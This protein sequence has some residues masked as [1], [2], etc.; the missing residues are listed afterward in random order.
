MPREVVMEKVKRYA[1]EIVPSFTA[2]AYF[3]VGTANCA[4]RLADALSGPDRLP[5][6][7]GAAPR[8]IRTSSVIFVINHRSNMDYVLVTYVAATSSALSYAVGEWA[9]V[10]GAARI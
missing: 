1:R 6:R 3:R 2:Y 10:W 8:S 4:R 9:Q 5:Q 7:R